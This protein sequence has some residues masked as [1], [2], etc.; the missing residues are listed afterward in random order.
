MLRELFSKHVIAYM[1]RQAKTSLMAL[2]LLFAAICLSAN[3]DARSKSE[4]YLFQKANPCPA[5]VGMQ[6]SARIRD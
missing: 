5:T 3:T 6:E 1:P 4:K 2:I